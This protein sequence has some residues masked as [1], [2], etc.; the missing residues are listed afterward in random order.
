MSEKRIRRTKEFKF[1]FAIE[2]IKGHKT[3]SELAA[4]FSVHPNQITE[5]KEELL[6]HGAEIFDSA[7]E[8][9]GKR[10]EEERNDLYHAVGQQKVQIDWLKKTLGVSRLPNDRAMIEA[11]RFIPVTKQCS[12]LDIPR[13]TAYYAAKGESEENQK[14][15]KRIDEL[16]T[17]NPAWGSRKIRIDRD[18]R[19]IR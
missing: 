17:E 8:R 16:Y 12:L 6:A 10:I 14:L 15:M 2:A 1:K 11:G 7:T 13:S 18:S 4:E 19:S 5:W 3:V 9:D